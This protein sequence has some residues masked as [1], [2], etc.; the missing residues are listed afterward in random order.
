MGL[1]HPKVWTHKLN[2]GYHVLLLN[3]S[4]FISSSCAACTHSMRSSLL[5][6]IRGEGRAER[7]NEYISQYVEVF[8]WLRHVWAWCYSNAAA[9]HALADINHICFAVWH[10]DM[11]RHL[12]GKTWANGITHIYHWLYRFLKG[13]L[14]GRITPFSCKRFMCDFRTNLITFNKRTKTIDNC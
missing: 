11:E 10:I 12:A 7:K 14:N 3:F 13:F 6:H 4:Y 8:H 9:F 2:S 1:C 5:N